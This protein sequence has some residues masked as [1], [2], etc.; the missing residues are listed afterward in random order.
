MRLRRSANTRIYR[1]HLARIASI[2]N[3][4]DEY[5]TDPHRTRPRNILNPLHVMN[6]LTKYNEQIG[7]IVTFLGFSK[8]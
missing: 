8:C 2:S 6:I 7:K 5:D 3:E 1:Y 4:L